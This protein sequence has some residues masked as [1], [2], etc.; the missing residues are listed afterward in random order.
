MRPGPENM[1]GRAAL[2][3]PSSIF[4]TCWPTRRTR[5][6]LR[7]PEAGAAV[8]GGADAS[9]WRDD[10]SDRSL[11]PGARRVSRSSGR[12]ADDLRRSGGHRGRE[13]ASLHRARSP[14]SRSDRSARAADR[15]E[16]HP[17][18]DQPIA[19]RCAAGV[20][21]HR[22]GCAGA[23]QRELGERLHVRR[24]ADPP[25][26]AREPESRIHRGDAQGVS[27]ATR[28]RHGGHRVRS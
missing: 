3:K 2:S 15:D 26:V 10:R 24:R 12:A 17:A 11:P 27:E 22:E 5:T 25:G 8:L 13:R 6:I 19:D 9:R 23:V 1:L 28:S 21:H 7:W 14:Q 18:R 20:R 4:P 16:R